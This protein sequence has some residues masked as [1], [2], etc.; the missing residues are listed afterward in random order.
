MPVRNPSPEEVALSLTLAVV[1]SS[2]APLLM[3]DGDLAIVAASTS[4]CEDFGLDPEGVA[5]QPLLTLHAGAWDTPQM[6]SLLV[7]AMSGEAQPPGCEL[8]VSSPGGPKRDLIVQAHRLN[9]LDLEQVRILLAVSDVTAARADRASNEDLLRHNDIL[10][11]EVRHRVANSLQIIASVLL[12]NARATPS[13][14]TRA[15]LKD[16]HNRVMS[17]AALERLLSTTGMGEV[18]LHAY[19]TSLCESLA[20][21][22]IGDSDHIS[23]SVQGG[24]GVAEG[25]V[26]MSLGL[27]V[28]E[29]VINALKYAFPDARPGKI[30]VDYNFHGPN[31]SLSVRDDGVGMPAGGAPVREGLGTSIVQALAK[32]LRASVTVIPERPGTKVSI[33]H[34]QIALVEDEPDAAPEP[35]SAV[36]PPPSAN[37]SRRTET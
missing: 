21:S 24:E 31:W 22:M 11:Q 3:L 32:Q 1:S 15:H 27:I 20:A 34:M 36:S 18:D 17:V 13:D 33:E 19:F 30:T 10:L 28:T 6:R 4:F 25:R 16:A 37:H 5:G 12:R 29:L 35:L 9:Y 14:E 2:P 23:L 26:S 7:A 8:D